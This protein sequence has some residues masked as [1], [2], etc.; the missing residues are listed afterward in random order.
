MRRRD[1]PESQSGVGPAEATS[2]RPPAW[3]GGIWAG[4]AA[5]AWVLRVGLGSDTWRGEEGKGQM[6]VRA[7]GV[8]NLRSAGEG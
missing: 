5:D 7:L 6:C 2:G 4:T 3:P 1:T 8:G